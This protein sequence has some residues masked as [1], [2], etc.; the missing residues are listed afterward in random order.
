MKFINIAI[1][2]ALLLLAGA[3]NADN[4]LD[5]QT[6]LTLELEAVPVIDV[7]NMIAQQNGLNL[8]VS[9]DVTG[10]VSVRL[11][12]VDSPRRSMPS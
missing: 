2:S 6:K 9:G 3:V 8:V 7:L 11:S 4:P 10:E 12:D 5:S 1:C